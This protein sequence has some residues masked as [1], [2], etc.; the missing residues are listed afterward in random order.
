M[1]DR[2]PCVLDILLCIC[3]RGETQP[4]SDEKKDPKPASLILHI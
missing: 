4:I 1:I 3:C 2:R